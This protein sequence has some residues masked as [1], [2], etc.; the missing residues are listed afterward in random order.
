VSLIEAKN[1]AM[2]IMNMNAPKGNL[3]Y[4]NRTETI[5]GKQWIILSL[6]PAVNKTKNLWKFKSAFIK[7][8]HIEDDKTAGVLNI[9]IE[10]MGKQYTFDINKVKDSLIISIT[11]INS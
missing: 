11:A 6:K 9:R 8:I 5:D 3:E 10:T 1:K 4:K 2:I 7:G